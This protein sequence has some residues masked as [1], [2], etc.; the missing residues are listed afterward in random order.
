MNPFDA[1]RHAL[2]VNRRTFLTQSA[3]GL[4]GLAMALMHQ[5]LAA[6]GAGGSP[7]APVTLP[8][9]WSGALREAHLPVKAKRVIFLCLSLIHI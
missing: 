8:P 7:G 9:G 6:A 3:Y 5:K 4:G 1:N 2:S